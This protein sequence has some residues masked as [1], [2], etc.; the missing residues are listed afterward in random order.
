[1]ALFAVAMILVGGIGYQVN[2]GEIGQ[3]LNHG[4]FEKALLREIEKNPD[5]PELYRALGSLYY[6]GK[7]YPQAIEFYTRTLDMSPNDP[8]T[9]N[10]LA[11]LY[12]TCEDESLRDPKQALRLAERA[13]AIDPRA[14]IL[15]TLAESYYINGLLEEAIR[16]ARAASELSRDNRSY[17]KGQLEKF[18]KAAENMK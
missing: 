6:K 13:A 12:A 17:F 16:T 4:F 18:R 2:F 5:H 10:N 14:H 8:E 9:L 1:M 7:K 15:D 11:W 3:R